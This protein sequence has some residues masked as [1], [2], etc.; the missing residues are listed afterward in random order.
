MSPCYVASYTCVSIAA[1]ISV[2]RYLCIN[3]DD[4][5]EK[6]CV[7]FVCMSGS[8]VWF[9]SKVEEEDAKLRLEEQID[10]RI[11][12]GTTVH[13]IHLITK[14]MLSTKHVHG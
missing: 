3:L 8:C 6:L 9:T 13:S 2:F 11:S 10:K 5:S 14:Y 4:D 7:L 12:N 1:F